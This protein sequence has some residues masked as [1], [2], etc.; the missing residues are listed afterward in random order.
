MLKRNEKIDRL[1]EWMGS[2][3]TEQDAEQ[4]LELAEER[5]LSFEDLEKMDEKQFFELV[6]DALNVNQ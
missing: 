1:M 6:D 4:V 2:E 5:G 3:A